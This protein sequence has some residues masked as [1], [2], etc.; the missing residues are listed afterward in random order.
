MKGRSG[1]L[2]H[3]E[4]KRE[5][6]CTSQNQG[7]R[8]INHWRRPLWDLSQGGQSGLTARM[9]AQLCP[10][11]PLTLLPHGGETAERAP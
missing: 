8:A 7:S 3:P 2:K 10:P 5:S 1:A 11:L 9:W 4:A 6:G